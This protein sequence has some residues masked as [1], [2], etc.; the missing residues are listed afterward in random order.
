VIGLKKENMYQCI[1]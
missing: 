1:T